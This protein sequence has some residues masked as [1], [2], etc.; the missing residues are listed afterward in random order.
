MLEEFRDVLKEVVA[1][2]NEQEDVIS[3]Q[4]IEIHFHEEGE[5]SCGDLG[6]TKHGIMSRANDW[7]LMVD[8]DNKAMFPVEVAS[9]T[10]RTDIVL[11]SL[12]TM[13]LV[14]AELTVPWEE[15]I[16]VANE[17]KSDKSCNVGTMNTK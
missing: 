15:N 5:Y 4:V 10:M 1:D 9:T 17:F 7:K 13:L 11:W 6:G 14:I 3:G 2:A 16:S 8:L 12:S